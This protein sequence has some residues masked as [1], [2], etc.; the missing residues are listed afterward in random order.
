[1]ARFVSS[2][3]GVGNRPRGDT[4]LRCPQGESSAHLLQL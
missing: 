3:G 4:L 1:V 2:V